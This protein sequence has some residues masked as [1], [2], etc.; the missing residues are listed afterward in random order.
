M[1]VFPFFPMEKNGE[2]SIWKER[3]MD[4]FPFLSIYFFFHFSPWGKMGKHTFF[5]EQ[6]WGWTPSIFKENSYLTILTARKVGHLNMKTNMF[7][8]EARIGWLARVF[9]S[10]PIRKRTSKSNIF[11]FMLRW[12]TFLTAS[13]FSLKMEQREINT[14]KPKLHLF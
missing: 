10:Q 1:C 3:E 5:H 2:K 7:E 12:P 13:I 11:A 14:S 9:V 6:K 8:F 4:T